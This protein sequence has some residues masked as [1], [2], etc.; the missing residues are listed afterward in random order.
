M[1]VD[2]HSSHQQDSIYVGDRCLTFLDFSLQESLEALVDFLAG[3]V[4]FDAV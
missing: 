2:D 4:S 1:L 3:Y